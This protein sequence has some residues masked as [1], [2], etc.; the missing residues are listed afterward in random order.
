MCPTVGVE[1]LIGSF[2]FFNKQFTSSMNGRPFN[3]CQST[4]ET[5]SY[6]NCNCRNNKKEAKFIHNSSIYCSLIWLLTCV[7][8]VANM[9][10]SM[11]HP[12]NHNALPYNMEHTHAIAT[13]RAWH[14]QQKRNQ[15]SKQRTGSHNKRQRRHPHRIGELRDARK[16][17]MTRVTVDVVFWW[18]WYRRTDM[19]IVAHT[20]YSWWKSRYGK[21]QKED[22]AW[23][24]DMSEWC[25]TVTINDSSSVHSPLSQDHT[26][27][28]KWSWSLE[29][30]PLDVCSRLINPRIFRLCTISE[31]SSSFTK[32]V[33]ST[34]FVRL[35]FFIR[36]R[37]TTKKAATHTIVLCTLR[38][39][40]DKTSSTKYNHRELMF[41]LSF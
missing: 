36:A 1:L 14:P 3:K 32:C 38:I 28:L 21:R 18:W 7:A 34:R 37:S 39:V 17:G 4:I 22:I 12:R 30:W 13:K 24:T 19:S 16:N 10:M 11:Y 5:A 40:S 31:A 29:S 9:L 33:Y 25:H 6:I 8:V 26:F 23:L 35:T 2:M 41:A 27:A 20:R 15:E